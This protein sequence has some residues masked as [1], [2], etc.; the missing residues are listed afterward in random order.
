MTECFC[1]FEVAAFLNLARDEF[2]NDRRHVGLRL[3]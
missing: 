2:Q 3:R 1:C